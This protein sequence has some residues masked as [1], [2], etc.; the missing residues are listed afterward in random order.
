MVRRLVNRDGEDL[1][2]TVMEYRL[3]CALASRPGLVL[4]HRQLL[5][6]V[7]GPGYVEHGHCL[8][9]DMGRLRHKRKTTRPA[10]ATC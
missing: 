1:R 9:I 5:R 10:R 2:L 7:W 4:T 8:R 3:L 6:E